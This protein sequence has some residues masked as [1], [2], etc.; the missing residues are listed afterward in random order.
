LR[1]QSSGEAHGWLD[2][3]SCKDLLAPK[4]GQTTGILYL[5]GQIATRNHRL[6]PNE[7]RT[8]TQVVASEIYQGR[9]FALL[10]VYIKRSSIVYSLAMTAN[11]NFLFSGG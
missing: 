2:L 11:W 1:A 10:T 4:Y 3:T 7:N 9:E 6:K 8:T 5:S